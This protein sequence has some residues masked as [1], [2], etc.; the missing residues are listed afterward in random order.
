MDVSTPQVSKES[1]TF[2]LQMLSSYRWMPGYLDFTQA[3][4]SGDQI[5]RILF[6]EQPAE[7]IPG[8][9][10]RQLLR[11]KKCCYGLLDGPYQWYVHLKRLLMEELDYEIS[12]ADP[13]VFYLFNKKRD[14]QRIIGV[15]TDDLLHGGTEEH[16]NRMRRIQGKY[17]LGKFS[18]GDGRF[19]GKEVKYDGTT[20]KL[21]QPLYTSEK[22][23]VIPLSKERKAEKMSYCTPEEVTLLRGLLGS[24]AWLSKETRPDLAGRVALL[25]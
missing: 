4:H 5:Q 11:L 3:F 7:G 9:K 6:A 21:C 23:K 20:I 25:Q 1:V 22:L 14:L 15:A 12:Q 10:P 2:L 24:L 17:K 13:C 16:G 8:M 19:A 18:Q